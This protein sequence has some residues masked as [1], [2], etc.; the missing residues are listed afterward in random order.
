MDVEEAPEVPEDHP[1]WQM[2]DEESA[3]EVDAADEHSEFTTDEDVSDNDWIMYPRVFMFLLFNRLRFSTHNIYKA[4][5]QFPVHGLM[6]M[7]WNEKVDE[8]KWRAWYLFWGW[9]VTRLLIL[10]KCVYNFFL[11]KKWTA[12]C[13]F[14]FFH[15]HSE[16]VYSIGYELFFALGIKDLAWYDR[17]L[18]CLNIRQWS[19]TRWGFVMNFQ[20]CTFVM[21]QFSLVCRKVLCW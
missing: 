15:S 14:S 3:E 17:I 1:Q 6:M 12:L 20:I 16:K 11:I 5:T 18:S 19:S 13:D 10:E 7:Y 21:F 8:M 2:S 4:K 9:I